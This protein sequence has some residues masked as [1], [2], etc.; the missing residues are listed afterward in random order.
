M[1]IGG[2]PE[3]VITENMELAKTYFTD[4]L[5]KDIVMRH[6]IRQKTVLEKIVLFF[7]SNSVKTIS[8]ESLILNL[9]LKSLVYFK[10]IQEEPIL[11]KYNKEVSFKLIKKYFAKTVKK[12][13]ID[14]NK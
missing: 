13:L 12:Y 7:I 2:F 5:Y 3:I 10:D 11:F 8:I 9:I 14:V 6:D 4:I 1:Q